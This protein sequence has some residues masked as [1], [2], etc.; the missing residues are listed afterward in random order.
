MRN[1][2]FYYNA[3]FPTRT[4]FLLRFPKKRKND[5]VKR[6][7]VSFFPQTTRHLSL[8]SV[9]RYLYEAFIL[10]LRQRLIQPLCCHVEETFLNRPRADILR[11][12]Y[13]SR[14]ITGLILNRITFCHREWGSVIVRESNENE[15]KV[16]RKVE[17]LWFTQATTARRC[18]FNGL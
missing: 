12:S 14:S 16:K 11:Y 18:E 4:Y 8:P 5:F 15:E 7:R 3:G 9:N 2:S 10:T 17:P 1:I 13:P 6:S